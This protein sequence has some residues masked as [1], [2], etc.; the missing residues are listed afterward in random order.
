MPTDLQRLFAQLNSM[1]V[2]F[3]PIFREFHVSTTSYPP[4]NII[5]ISDTELKLEMALAG[6][7]KD[8]V[9][10]TEHQGVLT[11]TGDK[12][13]SI[14][15]ASYQYRGIAGRSFSKSFRIAEYFEISSASLEDGILTVHF[16]KN[17][18]EEAKPKLIAIK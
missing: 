2:G 11:I 1:A 14:E 10:M 13:T 12:K 7:K 3:D 9:K 16:V 17:V 15:D 6:F 8:E 18:P 5:T 4:H